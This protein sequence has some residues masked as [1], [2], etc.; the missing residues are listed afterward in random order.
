MIP[1]GHR[2]H[3]SYLLVPGIVFLPRR[4]KGFDTRLVGG[5]SGLSFLSSFL[6]GRVPVWVFE[7]QSSATQTQSAVSGCLEVI[8]LYSLSFG[9]S[10]CSAR[11]QPHSRTPVC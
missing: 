6:H 7:K 8:I 5:P 3:A 4:L 1:Y 2:Y 10:L 9:D 11:V